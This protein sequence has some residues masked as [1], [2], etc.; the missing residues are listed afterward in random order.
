MEAKVL[1]VSVR[2]GDGIH[3]EIKRKLKERKKERK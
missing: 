1:E 2:K 3:K